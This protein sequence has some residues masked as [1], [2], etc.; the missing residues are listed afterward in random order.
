MARKCRGIS[1]IA[2]MEVAQVGMTTRA[3]TSLAMVVEDVSSTTTTKRRKL[4]AEQLKC[5]SSSSSSSSSLLFVK[6]RWRCL[7]ISMEAMEEHYY[8]SPNSDHDATLCC[9]SNGSSLLLS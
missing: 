4:H 9:L 3:R 8:S 1:N 2:V 6:L 5:S 7:T